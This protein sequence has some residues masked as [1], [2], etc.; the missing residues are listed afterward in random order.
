MDQNHRDPVGIIGFEH[1]NAGPILVVCWT[2]HRH[3]TQQQTGLGIIGQRSTEVGSQRPSGAG[4]PDRFPSSWIIKRK[5]GVAHLPPA[6]VEGVKSRA[7]VTGTA[8]PTSGKNCFPG[9]DDL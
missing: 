7:A 9:S 5:R 4:N 6:G 3:E 2:E 1:V 8:R